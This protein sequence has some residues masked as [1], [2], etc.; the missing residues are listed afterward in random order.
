MRRA[1]EAASKIG[2]L[3]LA[4]YSCDNLNTNL[5]AAGDPLAEAQRQAEHGLEFAKKARFGLII[6]I[7]KV[8]IGLIRTLR[9]LTPKFGSFDDRE[10]DELSFESHFANR[11]APAVS[12]C[13][14][15][16]RKLQARFLAGDYASAIYASS[17]AQ[18]V[19]CTATAVFET[20]EYQFYGA[21]SQA[22]SYD[23]A[24]ADRRQQHFAALAAHH[25]QLE[26]WAENCPENFENRAA[27][28][29]AE[30]ARIEG[31][32]VD[33]MDLYERAIRSA[34]ANGFV[35]NEALASELA[36]RFYAARGFEKI[37]HA[38]LREAR[39]LLSLLGSHW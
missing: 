12:E 7:I 19:L 16:V 37:A 3:T 31:R 38:Y 28:V 29:A 26:V 11:P 27:L 10:F 8:Q 30:I 25:R 9:G 2:D 14:Y 6:D 34:H 20:A 33:A 18:R 13:G 36:A 4:A 22:A 39:Y 23:S 17:R 15:W 35:H 1:F 5:L 32:T 24:A 21:L